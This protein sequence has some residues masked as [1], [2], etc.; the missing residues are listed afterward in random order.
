VRGHGI[1][2]LVVFFSGALV[3][4]SAAKSDLFAKTSCKHLTRGHIKKL[5]FKRAAS[6]VDNQN[7]HFV[8]ASFLSPCRHTGGER[9][10]LFSERCGIFLGI[11]V[12]QKPVRIFP[13]L[14]YQK[15]CAIARVLCKFGSNYNFDKL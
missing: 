2:D 9:V 12:R 13:F 4:D 7:F 15:K 14:L 6:G 11:F 5:I 3:S 1:V 8:N 10:N